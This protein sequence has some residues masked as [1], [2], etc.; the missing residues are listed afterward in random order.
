MSMPSKFVVLADV[1]GAAGGG[2]DTG[3]FSTADYD[4]LQ[5]YIALT[6]GLS[7]AGTFPSVQGYE[8]DGVTLV[9][10]AGLGLT[11]G[12]SYCSFSI[13][14]ASLAGANIS[15]ACSQLVCAKTRV[16][17]PVQGVGITVRI[18]VTGRRQ[19]RGSVSVTNTIDGVTP[20]A[21]D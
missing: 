21:L 9:S 14:P 12:V 3:V 18:I 1:A 16:Q 7:P 11:A 4:V 10:Q 20:R 19:F 5:V 6:G 2:A 15:P 8:A 13:S 17:C